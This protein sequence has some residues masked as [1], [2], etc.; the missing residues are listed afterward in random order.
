MAQTESLWEGTSPATAYPPLSGDLTVDAVVIGGGITGLTTAYLLARAGV[1]VALL[2]GRS[3]ATGTTGRT[4]AKVTS[5][6]GL[7][8]AQ[9]IKQ[10][11]EES[12]RVYGNANQGAL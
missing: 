3:I 2:E 1:R 12:A 6:H 10:H 5:L 4:T 9:L 11:G 8:Y 7:R